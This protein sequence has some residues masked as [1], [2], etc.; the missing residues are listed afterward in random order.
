MARAASLCLL[1]VLAMFAFAF[2]CAD[3]RQINNS[4]NLKGVSG[5]QGA[6][7]RLSRRRCRCR[8]LRPPAAACR[9]RPSAGPAHPAGSSLPSARPPLFPQL[10]DSSACDLIQSDPQL[11]SMADMMR[12]YCDLIKSPQVAPILAQ[13][14]S[15]MGFDAADVQV[16]IGCICG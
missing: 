3:A 7:A 6:A 12:P 15:S 16:V 14:A 4:R 9:C 13:A 1:A 8:C 11:S 10:L 5:L 2:A